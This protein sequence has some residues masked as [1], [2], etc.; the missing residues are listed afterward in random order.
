MLNSKLN[1]GLLR[2]CFND[3]T[4]KPLLSS[5]YMKKLIHSFAFNQNQFNR[6]L[7]NF[8]SAKVLSINDNYY[9]QTLFKFQK[10]NLNGKQKFFYNSFIAYYSI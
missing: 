2:E 10:K 6:N 9:K 3:K 7:K 4:Y 8:S 5:D 1:K